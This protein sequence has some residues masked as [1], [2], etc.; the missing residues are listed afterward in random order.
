MSLATTGQA[1]GTAATLCEQFGTT[2]AGLSEAYA[3][4]L[5]QTLLR[6][7]Q[8]IIGEPNRDDD[9]TREASVSASSFQPPRL[10]E[11]GTTVP[12]D[13]DF[14]LHLSADGHLDAVELLLEADGDG[15]SVEVG[16]WSEHRPEN[17]VP[18]QRESSETVEVPGE[19]TWVE[20]PVGLDVSESQG[21][22]LVLSAN[23]DLDVHRPS[24]S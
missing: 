9:L 24:G 12:L 5:K 4:E 22:F 14:G 23:P 7:D 8:W 17:Y 1:A 11:A 6:E 10:E 21:V 20:I 3:E 13:D 2:P 16:V 15:A 18:H 19:P